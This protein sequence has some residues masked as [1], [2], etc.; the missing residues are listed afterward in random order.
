MGA[1]RAVNSNYR[2]ATQLGGRMKLSSIPQAY[3]NVNRATEIISVLSKYGLADWLSR[4]NLEFAKS[5]LKGRDG[6]ELARNSREARIRMTLTELGP[7]FIKLGQVLSMRPDVVGQKLADELCQL[8]DSAPA[9]SFEVV[10]RTIEEDLGQPIPEL[11]AEFDERPL[12]SASIGQVHRA[13]LPSGENVVVKVQRFG[14]AE[15]IRKDLDVMS[16]LVQMIDRLPEFAPYRPT[17]TLHELQKALKRELDFTRELRNL[18]QFSTRYAK[19]IHVRIPHP[20]EALCTSRVLTMQHLDGISVDKIAHTTGHCHDLEAIA[21]YGADL[22]L[23]MIFTEGLYHADPHPGNVLILPGDVIGLLDFGMVGRLDEE[24][25]EQIEE[26]LVAVVQ[27]DP[28]L[29]AS[30]LSRMGHMP[31]GLDESAFRSDLADFISLYSGQSLRQIEVGRLLSE[32]MEMIHRYRIMLPSQVGLL[33]KTLVTLE[34]TGKLMSPRFS[35]MELMQPL[36]RRMMSRR[37]SPTR[38]FRQLRRIYVELEQLATVLPRRALQIIEQIE[39][40]EFDIHLDHRGLTPSINRLV[41]GMLSSALFLGSS[42]MLGMKVP[43]LL[44]SKGGVLGFH[45]VSLLGIVGY[46]ASLFLGWRL[47]AAIRKSSRPDR[48]S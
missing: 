41:T 36:Q 46:G 45:E 40:G 19:N 29:L 16:G 26:M 4:L 30:A 24:L 20:V 10:K 38:R 48:S 25:R 27:R 22:Y 33:I 18:K 44:F 39:S 31:R 23:H 3:R 8:R 28:M 11:F 42:V 13:R 1:V 2:R 5:F 47:L 43:P 7:T 17:A 35:I 14:I 12:A 9:D 37:L 34:G 15:T 6:A 21:R 32:M